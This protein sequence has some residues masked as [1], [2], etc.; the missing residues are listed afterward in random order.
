MHGHDGVRI[1]SVNLPLSFLEKIV[2]TWKYQG[3]VIEEDP[4]L[5]PTNDGSQQK[6]Y[7]VTDKQRQLCYTEQNQTRKNSRTPVQRCCHSSVQD[8]NGIHWKS[9]NRFDQQFHW[10]RLRSFQWR[11]SWLLA[12]LAGQAVCNSWTGGIDMDPTSWGTPTDFSI[13]CALL[14]LS[15]TEYPKQRWLLLCWISIRRDV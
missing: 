6:C 11:T 5:Y 15:W 10:L 14:I 9:M 13:A 7:A 3:V 1:F 4:G 2:H 8:N 12:Y